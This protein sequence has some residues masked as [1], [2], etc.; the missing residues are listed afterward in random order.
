[1]LA[2]VEEG[3]FSG[4]ARRLNRAQSAVTYAVQRLEE[5]LGAALFDRASYRASLTEAGRSLLPRARLIA[6]E[7]R[8]VVRSGPRHF[9]GP[10]A[11]TDAGGRGHVPDGGR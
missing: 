9:R 11:G 4:A 8:P 10:G 7:M 3:S 2:V 1:M 6:E 5:E